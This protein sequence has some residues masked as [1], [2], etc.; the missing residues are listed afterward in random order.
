MA[1]M[2]IVYLPLFTTLYLLPGVSYVTVTTVVLLFFSV[3]SLVSFD[4]TFV[5]GNQLATGPIHWRIIITK[6]PPILYYICKYMY[7]EII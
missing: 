4:G 5:T 3:D 7:F 1:G 6:C 2:F